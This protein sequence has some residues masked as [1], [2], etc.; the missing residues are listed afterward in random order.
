LHRDP[1]R[2]RERLIATSIAMPVVCLLATLLSGCSPPSCASGSGQAMTVYTLYFGRSV[3]GRAAVGDSEWRDFR[4]QVITKALP[5]GY[6]VLDAQ[7]AWM[8]P[9]SHA[10]IS[11]ATKVLIVALPDAPGGL[12]VINR[13]RSAWQHRFHQYV[14]GMT[15][16]PA[17][18]SFSPAE[19]PP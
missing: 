16:Q 5:N 6:T 7:G 14:V 12:G 11:E 2:I 15:A 17:C 19:V 9:R 8:N 13:I 1:E 10:T 4:D 3:A 18:G